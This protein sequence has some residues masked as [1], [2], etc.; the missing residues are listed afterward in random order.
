MKRSWTPR[1]RGK[2]Y[3]S[4][5][6]GH[7]CTWSEHRKAKKESEELAKELGRGFRPWVR[8]NLGWHCG[9]VSPVA[10][11]IK[12]KGSRWYNA[13]LDGDGPEFG[14]RWIGNGLTPAGALQMA[15]RRAREEYEKLGN[16][17]KRLQGSVKAKS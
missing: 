15:V 12:N 13:V 17:L 5:G 4:S 10:S 6:C 11:V 8:E 2:V 9:A 14:S 1:R 16:L 3:C 7:G